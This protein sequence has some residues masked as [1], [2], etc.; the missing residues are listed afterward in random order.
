MGKLVDKNYLSTFPNVVVKPHVCIRQM[1]KIRDFNWNLM[2]L[3][4]VSTYT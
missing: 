4:L 1:W 3:K 2:K